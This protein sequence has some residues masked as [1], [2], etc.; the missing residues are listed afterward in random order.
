VQFGWRRVNAKRRASSGEGGRGFSARHVRLLSVACG[1]GRCELCEHATS[2]SV[3]GLGNLRR[4]GVETFSTVVVVEV[5]R[6]DESTFLTGERPRLGN[7]TIAGDT[8][9]AWV[10]S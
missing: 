7:D 5:R 9:K 4:V 8:V 2:R 10:L 3:R 1:G 6:T